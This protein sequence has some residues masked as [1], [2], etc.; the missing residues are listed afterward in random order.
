MPRA[1]GYLV[2]AY[3]AAGVVCG[4]FAFVAV[5]QGRYRAA[6]LLL[7]LATV[8]DATD[9]ALAR[10]ARVSTTAP[11]IDGAHLDDIVDYVTYVFVPGVLVWHAGLLPPRW[12]EWVIAL[13]LIASACGFARRDA[14]T[15]DHFFTGFPSYWN[16]VAVYLLALRL[17]Q[18]ANAAILVALALLVF[19]PIRYVYPSR[20]PVAMVPTIVL[21]TIWGVLMLIVVWELPDPPRWAVWGTMPFAVYYTVLSFWLTYTRTC[22]D[23]SDF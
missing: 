16:V 23:K 7:I 12:A 6:L 9:G 22:A 1:F 3:T 17:P 10:L 5:L 18:E 15:A 8:I 19:V 13:T 2:H 14:K 4:W 11:L 20:T 21:G